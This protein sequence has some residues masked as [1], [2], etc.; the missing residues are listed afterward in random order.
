[1]C[2]GIGTSRD[3][4]SGPKGKR[5]ELKVAVFDDRGTWPIGEKV[6]LIESQNGEKGITF[7]QN[8][9]ATMREG[10]PNTK[11]SYRSFTKGGI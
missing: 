2:P 3:L 7:N 4:C 6:T 5:R 9:G 10:K 8:S 11:K 1:V